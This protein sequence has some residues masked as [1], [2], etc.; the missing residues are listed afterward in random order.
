MSDDKSPE[1]SPWQ[2]TDREHMAA[3]FAAWL[4]R[5]LRERELVLLETTAPSSADDFVIEVDSDVDSDSGNG[6]EDLVVKTCWQ[7]LR[8]YTHASWAR[9]RLL[10]WAPLPAGPWERLPD[11]HSYTETRTCASC[12]TRLMLTTGRAPDDARR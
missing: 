7:C 12:G 3:V 9:L 1:A 5:A 2:E 6:V 10:H 4:S 8:V 11:A